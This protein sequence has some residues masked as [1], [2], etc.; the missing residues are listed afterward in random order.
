MFIKRSIDY[1]NVN[2][3]IDNYN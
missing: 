1:D 2:Q 3:S